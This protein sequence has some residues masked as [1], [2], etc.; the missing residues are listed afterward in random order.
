MIILTKFGTPDE[1]GDINV[2]F[3]MHYVIDRE[4]KIVV[5]TQ[6]VKGIDA[7]KKELAKQ[8]SIAK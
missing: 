1:N 3:P 6:G 4:G 2:P 8:A 5:K 7:V